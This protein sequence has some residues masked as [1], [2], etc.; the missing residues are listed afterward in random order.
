MPC[1]QFVVAPTFG[2][3]ALSELGEAC[4]RR[5]ALAD[6]GDVGAIQCRRGVSGQLEGLLETADG[7]IAEL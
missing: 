5:V 3:G 7:E 1:R 2:P 4:P 6:A